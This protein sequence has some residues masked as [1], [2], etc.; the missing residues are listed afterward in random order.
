[1]SHHTYCHICHRLLADIDCPQ[2][3]SWGSLYF[4]ELARKCQPTNRQIIRSQATTQLIKTHSANQAIQPLLLK[5]TSIIYCC[6]A[7]SATHQTS[8]VGIILDIY[9]VT[10]QATSIDGSRLVCQPTLDLQMLPTAFNA[11]CNVINECS[12]QHCIIS[13]NKKK[14]NNQ[15]AHI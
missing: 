4:K 3:G 9:D 1:M 8:E 14:I 10:E 15:A 13:Y 7:N 11:V 12:L 6:W 2:K 5:A